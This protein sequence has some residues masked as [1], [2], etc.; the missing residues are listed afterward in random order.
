MNPK[1]VRQLVWKGTGMR[2]RNAV[3]YPG[4]PFFLPLI[5]TTL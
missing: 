1:V 4:D 3:S 2:K 5:S